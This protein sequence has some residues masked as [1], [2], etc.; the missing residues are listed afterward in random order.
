ML[1]LT[2]ESNRLESATIGKVISLSRTMPRES[3]IQMTAS[4]QVAAIR[5]LVEHLEDAESQYSLRH[6]GLAFST[7]ATDKILAWLGEV[8]ARQPEK[9]ALAKPIVKDILSIR[10]VYANRGMAA[11]GKDSVKSLISSIGNW[12]LYEEP[13][14]A[15]LFAQLILKRIKGPYHRVP[16]AE[17]SLAVEFLLSQ[18]KADPD[19]LAKRLCEIACNEDV[20]LSSAILWLLVQAKNT[21]T[22][23]RKT[24][25]TFNRACEQNRNI[26]QSIEAGKLNREDAFDK[27][28]ERLHQKVPV[29]S[30]ESKN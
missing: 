29:R 25:D 2:T 12:P 19:F 24:L 30:A 15:E 14:M 11:V 26:L 1:L 17:F 27:P 4:V 8:T 6:A 16:A 28:L 13:D 20:N 9:R 5:L 23:A 18:S 22:V 10:T 7:E 21:S 3:S